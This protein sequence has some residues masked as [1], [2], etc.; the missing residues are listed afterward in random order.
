MINLSCYRLANLTSQVCYF[1]PNDFFRS[2][3]AK[4]VKGGLFPHPPRPSSFTTTGFK[5]LRD[6]LSVEVPITLNAAFCEHH[7][8]SC[9]SSRELEDECKVVDDYVSEF[10]EKMQRLLQD[11]PDP[12]LDLHSS[13][14]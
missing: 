5:L 10:D 14:M 4:A 2:T 11:L 7:R 6:L 3:S 1:K 13:C 12:C 9:V 8:L